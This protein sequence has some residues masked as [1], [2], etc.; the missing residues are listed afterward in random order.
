VDHRM[1]LQ[2]NNRDFV[3]LIVAR[4]GEALVTTS[5]FRLAAT[6]N[7]AIVLASERRANLTITPGTQLC[8]M[9]M[10]RDRLLSLT[11]E[12]FGSERAFW[13]V[14][15]GL[16]LDERATGLTQTIEY[17][18]GQSTWSDLDPA[19]AAVRSSEQLL[20]LAFIRAVRHQHGEEA[21]PV[22]G[23]TIPHTVKLA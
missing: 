2:L 6:P 10:R 22:V 19:D 17:V 14:D 7:R 4:A 15:S 8:L 18:L 3:A 21:W 11:R 5:E 20:G 16:A 1:S 23:E 13:R 12:Y 9:R